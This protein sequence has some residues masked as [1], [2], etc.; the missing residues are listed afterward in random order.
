MRSMTTIK[1]MT[2]EEARAYKPTAEELERART[3]KNTDFSDCPKMTKEDLKHFKR[4]GSIYK[5]LKSRVTLRLDKD[6]I[7]VFKAEG[8]GYQT[9]INEVLR[10]YISEHPEMLR[11]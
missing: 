11:V 9:R 4:V 6:I 3:F 1:R 2:M 5:P 10:E 8:R 7:E